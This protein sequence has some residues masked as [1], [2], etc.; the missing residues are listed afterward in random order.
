MIIKCRC[1]CLTFDIIRIL[2]VCL[3]AEAEGLANLLRVKVFFDQEIN[4]DWKLLVNKVLAGSFQT[5]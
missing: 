5:G 4:D 1:Y 2:D 3:R